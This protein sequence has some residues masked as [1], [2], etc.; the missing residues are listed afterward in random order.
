MLMHRI[1][2]TVDD[3]FLKALNSYM[4][5]GGH[6][7]R[8]EALRDLGRYAFQQASVIVPENTICMASL[9]Y[10]YNFNERLMG[11]K[12][13][14]FY[15]SSKLFVTSTKSHLH[16]DSYL[17]VAILKGRR[18]DIEALAKNIVAQKGIRHGNLQI[19]PITNDS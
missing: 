15:G 1:T 10:A 4:T 14:D 3:E 17:E 5:L 19:Y 13:N 16:E 2:L 12:L 18:K 6:C 9:S 11:K 7:S 8:S